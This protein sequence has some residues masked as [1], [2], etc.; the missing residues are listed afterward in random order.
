[1]STRTEDRNQGAYDPAAEVVEIC[2]DLIRIDTTN[3]GDES[4]PGERKAAEHVAALLDE[5]GIESEIFE[6]VEGRT[7][8][9]ARWGSGERDPLLLHGHLDVVPAEADDWAVPPFSGEVQ[10]G[11]LWGRGAVDM[12]DFD[13][14][15]LSVVRARARAGA[16]PDRPMVLCFTADE[17]AGGH[18]GAEQIVLKRPDL[19]DGCTEAIGEVGG[20][21]ATVRGR[22]LY[23]IEAAE[24]GMAWM[25]L[26]A[27]GQRRPRVDAPPRQ[28]GDGADD[29]GGAHRRP[30]VAGAADPVDEGAALRGR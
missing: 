8:V 19:L 1:M 6:G 23:L 13:A 12:K 27:S 7:N 3:Y 20:F 21:S 17:E 25:R 2:R 30:R 14:M 9:V 24:K 16:K 5:V 15:L 28:R 10:D 26:T 29:G 4:G 11:C 18:Q 22:R